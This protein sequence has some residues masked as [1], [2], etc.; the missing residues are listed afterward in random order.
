[1]ADERLVIRNEE[2]PVY[3]PYTISFPISAQT[4]IAERYHQGDLICEYFTEDQRVHMQEVA[5]D[6]PAISQGY[7]LWNMY[8]LTNYEMKEMVEREYQRAKKEWENLLSTSI[9]LEEMRKRF[10]KRR[11]K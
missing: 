4:W 6:W 5:M 3:A 2:T 8:I 9:S 10:Q 11:N 1:M 7:S